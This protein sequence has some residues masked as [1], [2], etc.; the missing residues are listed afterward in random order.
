MKKLVEI[1]YFSDD[2]EKMASFYRTLTGGDPV[3]ASQDM[4]IF[5]V[6]QT[7]I[8]IHK[9]YAAGD[10]ELPPE[11]HTAYAVSDVEATCQALAEK[12][13]RIERPPKDYYWGRSA[14]LRDPEGHLIELIEESPKIIKGAS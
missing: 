12:G 8:F 11:N 4:A 14:Y 10:G 9:T 1:A 2:I 3:A 13:L 6:G 7:Q 5:M